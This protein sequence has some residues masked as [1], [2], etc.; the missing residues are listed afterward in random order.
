MDSRRKREGNPW[1]DQK[2]NDPFPLGAAT[3]EPDNTNHVRRRTECPQDHPAW[4]VLILPIPLP[5][6][7]REL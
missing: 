6:A 1:R 2:G 4:P 3:H 5:T 7:E